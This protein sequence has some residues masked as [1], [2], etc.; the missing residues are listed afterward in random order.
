LKISLGAAYTVE[1]EPLT[2][3]A[4]LIL[5]DVQ[6]AIDHP[7]WSAYGE[8][9]NPAAEQSMRRLLEAW[10][11]RGAAV[12]HIRHDSTYPDSPYR[13]GQA[14]NDFKREVAPLPGEAIVAK[15][16]NSAFIGTDLEQRLRR[17]GHVSLVIAGVITNNSV[18]ATVRMS[19]NLGFDTYLAE[20]G[21]FTFARRDWAGNLHSAEVVH[22]LSVANMH[23]E[24]C[25]ALSVEEILAARLV[26]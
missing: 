10:R 13:P 3:E 2:P 6:N 8:R 26:S 14:G 11:S 1:V 9:N 12:Y 4:A 7:K 17:A 16:T 22:A 25:T 19:G 18:E 20:D 5:I 24:Y 23:E 15:Q 21:C